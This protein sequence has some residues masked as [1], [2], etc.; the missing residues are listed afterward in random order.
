[1][2]H[3]FMEYLALF[4]HPIKAKQKTSMTTLRTQ[5]CPITPQLIFTQPRSVHFDSQKVL[6]EIV[7]CIQTL[8]TTSRTDDAPLLKLWR[9]VQMALLAPLLLIA[10]GFKSVYDFYGKHMAIY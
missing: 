5:N 3:S 8:E 9:R 1:M 2:G 4:L 10:A 6:R 7:A